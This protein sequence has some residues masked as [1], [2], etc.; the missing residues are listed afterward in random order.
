MEET[1]GQLLR[2]ADAIKRRNRTVSIHALKGFLR[3][4]HFQPEPVDNYY[5]TLLR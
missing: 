4:I 5:A 1:Y 3:S 2:F